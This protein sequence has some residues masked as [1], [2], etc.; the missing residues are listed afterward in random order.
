LGLVDDLDRH[1]LLLTHDGPTKEMMMVARV[2]ALNRTAL[3]GYNGNLDLIAA[4]V[5][6]GKYLD[7]HNEIAAWRL[8][9]AASHTRLHCMPT[10]LDEDLALL[11]GGGGGGWF[12]VGAGGGGGAGGLGEGLTLAK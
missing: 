9:H 12:F 10:T 1:R 11:A 2:L 7:V 6:S 8:L 3:A 5:A 4:R